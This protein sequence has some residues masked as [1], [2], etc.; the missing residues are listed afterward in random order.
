MPAA[1]QL[2]PHRNSDASSGRHDRFGLSGAGGSAKA[3]LPRQLGHGGTGQAC[4]TSTGPGSGAGTRLAHS[5]RHMR[6]IGPFFLLALTFA[7]CSMEDD[8]GFSTPSSFCRSW[9]S[10]AC[11]NEVVSA[12]QA[13]EA[14]DCRA[15]QTSFCLDQLPETNFSGARADECIQAVK[16]AYSDADL[17][18]DELA[19]VLRFAAPCDRLVLGSSVEGEVCASSRDC[20]GPGLDCVFKG[21]SA[22]GTCQFGE[23]VGAGQDCRA[24]NATC[25][26]GFYC[27]GDNCIAGKRLGEACSSNAQCGS[28]GFCGLTSVCEARRAVS[29]SCGFDDQCTSGLCYQ[30]SASDQVCADR[31][32]LSLTEPLCADLR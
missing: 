12:C 1:S 15:S 16:D 3:S 24:V 8:D 4:Q 17:T 5:E 22:S 27:N 21:G 28:T 32:R 20:D 13:A 19:V 14:E 9:A 23:T 29:E 2:L 11:S 25:E 7:S 31:V 18:A 30:I 26:E 10:A 6:K